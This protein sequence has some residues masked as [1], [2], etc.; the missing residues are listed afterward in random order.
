MASMT[1]QA[2]KTITMPSAPE[3]SVPDRSRSASGWTAADF[4]SR[5]IAHLYTSACSS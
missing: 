5:W 1:R 3:E 2:S 4:A